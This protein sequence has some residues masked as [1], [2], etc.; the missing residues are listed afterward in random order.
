MGIV[1]RTIL[2]IIG[3]ALTVYFARAFESR[4]HI[5]LQAEHLLVLENEY[6]VNEDSGLDWQGYL[7]LE[8][9]LQDELDTKLVSRSE[10]ASRLNRHAKDSAISPRGH[11]RNWNLSFRSDPLEAKGSAVLIHGLTDSPYSMR[12]TAQDFTEAGF[13]TFTPRMPGHGFNVGSLASR[14]RHDWMGVVTLTVKAADAAR[15]P[16]QPL[17]IGGYS[18]GGI[19]A[20]KYAISCTE[21][22]LPCPDRILLLS[23]AIAIS[24]FAWFG[25]LHE[26]IS[27]IPY[28]SQFQWASIHPEVDAYKFTSFPTS[29]GFH[30]AQLAEEVGD[31]LSGGDLKLAPVLA[32]QSVVDATVSTD[33]VLAFFNQLEG[34]QHELVFYDMNRHQYFTEWITTKLED[35]YTFEKQAPLPISVTILSNHATGDEQVSEFRLVKGSVQ[36]EVTSTGLVWPPAVYSLSH[37]A[38]P[39]RPDDPQYGKEGKAIGT[40]QPRGE[41]NVISLGPDYFQRLRYNPFYEYQQRRIKSW[42]AESM[43]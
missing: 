11:E 34:A 2:I 37:I 31:A 43:E 15:K 39:F 22:D 14:S 42:L 20:L 33:A 21:H 7:Q 29:P 10:V 17:V 41:R 23:P 6:D 1:K 28:F 13:V 24:A 3:I 8:K 35:V 30:T 36:Y 32:F 27:W 38:I 12:A 25:R 4:N 40:F 26:F 9:D 5:P 19:L 18:N 16:G